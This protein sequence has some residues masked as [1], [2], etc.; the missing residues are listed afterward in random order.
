V[1]HRTLLLLLFLAPIV[2]SEDRDEKE[3]RPQVVFHFTEIKPGGSAEKALA[4]Y[5]KWVEGGARAEKLP[6]AMEAMYRAAGGGSAAFKKVAHLIA[7]GLKPGEVADKSLKH[8]QISDAHSKQM[9]R[10]R[11]AEIKRVIHEILKSRKGEW[12]LGRSDSGNP[13]SG[14][15]SDLDQT[16]Y[17]L[18]K[19]PYGDWVRDLNADKEFIAEFNERFKFIGIDALDIASIEGKQRFPDPRDVHLDFEGKF[20]ETIDTLRRTPGAYTY[21]GAVVSQM[22]LRALLA[23]LQGKERSFMEY[24]LGKNGELKELAFNKDYAKRILFGLRPAL[25]PGHAYGAAV[26]N[27]LTLQTYIKQGK[28]DPKYHLR[29]W[30]DCGQLLAMVED[31]LKGGLHDYIDLPPEEAARRNK[32][33]V[34]TMFSDPVKQKR[35]RLALDASAKLRRIHKG[36]EKN[37]R[38]VFG[39]KVPPATE[40]DSKVFADLARELYDLKPTD[41]PTDKQIKGAVTEHRRLASEFCLES[42]FR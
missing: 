22:Q 34:D 40:Y 38:T 18:K 8:L 27:Y 37:L 26:A 42:V 7:K 32:E 41:V 11:E 39:D 14:M 29:V 4:E 10:V 12:K 33:V 25:M 23:T 35:H 20:L 3:E 9:A 28:I 31:R 16:I 2:S 30:D 6:A 1:S 13:D 24:E 19:G 36:G 17:V 5:N 15:K 21:P